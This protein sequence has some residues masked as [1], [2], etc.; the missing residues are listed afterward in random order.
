MLG[1]DYAQAR[2]Q[3]VEEVRRSFN[4]VQPDEYEEELQTGTAVSYT[5]LRA[6]ETSV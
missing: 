2:K 5:H 1:N 6:H 4:H 3:Y